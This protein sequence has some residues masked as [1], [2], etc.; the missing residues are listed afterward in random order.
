[1]FK[2]LHNESLDIDGRIERFIYHCDEIR[3]DMMRTDPKYQHHYHSGYRMVSVYLSFKY[4]TKYCVYDYAAFRSFMEAVG[5]KPIPTTREIGRFFKV[6]RTVY[7]ILAK[8][9]EFLDVQREIKEE[10]PQ[11]YQAESLLLI[12]GFYRY[13]AMLIKLA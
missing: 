2:E 12:E 9:Q 3:D 6:M 8:D 10:Y 5:A 1:M 13:V 11:V 7:K 4:P